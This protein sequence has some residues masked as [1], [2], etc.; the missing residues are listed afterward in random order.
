MVDMMAWV[1]LHEA[2]REALDTLENA[3][4]LIPWEDPR[5]CPERVSL[6]LRSASWKVR[7][8]CALV[9][10]VLRVGDEE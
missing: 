8:A 5:R 10:G 4:E 1:E 2:L 9:G 6:R 3:E 7:E